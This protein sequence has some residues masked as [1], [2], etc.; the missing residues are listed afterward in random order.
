MRWTKRNDFVSIE[1]VILNN[2]GVSDESD[3]KKWSD[4]MNKV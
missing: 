2:L 4:P 1:Q 3:L